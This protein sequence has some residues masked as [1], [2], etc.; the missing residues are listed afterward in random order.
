MFGALKPVYN[1]LQSEEKQL[2]KKYYCGLCSSLGRLGGVLMRMCLSYDIA[3]MYMLLDTEGPKCNGRCHCPAKFFLKMDCIDNNPL[4]DYV[5][6][7]SIALLKGK[8]IDNINDKDNV[9]KSKILLLFIKKALKKLEETHSEVLNTVQNGLNKFNETEKYFQNKSYDNLADDFG[10][11][12]GQLFEKAPI[13]GD[14]ELF[15]RLGY[16]I[17]RWIYL[18][19]ASS[20]IRE[21]AEKNRFNPFVINEKGSVVDTVNKYEAC[22]SSELFKAHDCILELIN[23]NDYYDNTEKLINII[24]TAMDSA[25]GNVFKMFEEVK[26]VK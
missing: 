4:S 23:L 10:K 2:Y 7:V 5:S 16:W 13:C 17:G 24:S 12:A 6:A 22:I 20:D 14:S 8:C 21:D 26:N 3:F 18:I 19:D 11:L 9:F 1:K 25:E 15:G